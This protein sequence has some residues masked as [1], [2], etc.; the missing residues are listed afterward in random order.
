MNYVSPRLV[1]R[2][3]GAIFLVASLLSVILCVS[4][5]ADNKAMLQIQYKALSEVLA[6]LPEQNTEE[7]FIAVVPNVPPPKP[8]E[9]EA[10]FPR[11]MALCHEIC[12]GTLVR[13]KPHFD[14]EDK[15]DGVVLVYI[16]DE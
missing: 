16:P 1:T 6:Q 9:L 3:F 2:I 13:I 4:A 5:H 15:V 10:M 7:L 14:S 11:F 8:E 12:R